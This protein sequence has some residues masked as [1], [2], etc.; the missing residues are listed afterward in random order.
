MQYVR[1]QPQG[2]EVSRVVAGVWRMAQWGFD[3]PRTLAW[4]QACLDLGITTFD[5]ADIYGKFTCEEQFGGALA[6]KPALRAQMQIVTKCGIRPQGSGEPPARVKHYNS[7]AAYIAASV[8]RS[9]AKLRCETIDVLLLHRPDPLMDADAVADVFARL[10]AAGKVRYFGVSN[11]T[12]SQ[13]ALLQSRWDAPLVTNQVE[14]SLRQTEAFFNGVLDHAQSQRA[15]PMAWSPLAGGHLLQEDFLSHLLREIT[16]ELG[17][18]TP[19]QTA[20]AWLLAHPAGIVP[21][22]GSSQPQRL[23]QAAAA[24][25]MRMGREDWFRLWSAALGRE[26]P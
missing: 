13:T 5:H 19:E 9:L 11:H 17:L 2:P 1:L 4:I 20:L 14:I 21:V 8:D 26:V 23:A 10:R 25:E 18:Q 6:L 22:L 16:H 7:E 12:V 24:V 3:T 15:R